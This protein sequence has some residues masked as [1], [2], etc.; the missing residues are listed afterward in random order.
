MSTTTTP[1]TSTAAPQVNWAEVAEQWFKIYRSGFDTVL[2]VSNAAL[3]GAERMQMAQLEADVESQTCN[4][5]AALGVA[6]CRDMSGLLALQSNLASAY[7][8][9]SMRYWTTLAQLAQ[10]NAEIARLSPHAARS[11]AAPC[12]VRFR[13]RP[14]RPNR[15]DSRS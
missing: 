5:T 11:G 6:D 14:A 9:S 10:S 2:A 8:E 1:E 7:L 13:P 15:C 3:A 12:R 4:R